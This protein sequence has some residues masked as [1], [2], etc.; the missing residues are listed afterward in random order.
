VSHAPAP[1]PPSPSLAPEP[2]ATGKLDLSGIK[3]LDATHIEIPHTLV[4]AMLAEPMAVMHSIRVVATPNEAHPTGYKLYAIRP[5][6][7]WDL[8]GLANGDTLLTVAG[9]ALTSPDDAL[10]VVATLQ[11][12]TAF[13]VT[14]TRKGKP[15]TL[16]YVVP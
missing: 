1:S 15:L 6:S 12:A 8:A 14:L 7:L 5:G 3:K 9:Q 11:T 13:T 16:E 2:Q 4:Q 10:T